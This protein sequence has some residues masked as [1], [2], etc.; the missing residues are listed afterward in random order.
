MK[1]ARKFITLW[2]LVFLTSAYAFDTTKARASGPSDNP[3]THFIIHF[4][5]D[6]SDT[7][8]EKTL[9]SYQL[10]L[11]KRALKRSHRAVEDQLLKLGA[12]AVQ[13]DGA[14]LDELKSLAKDLPEILSI[15]PDFVAQKLATTND[16]DLSKQWGLFTIQAASSN[17]TSTWDS[18]IGKPEV[19][20]AVLDTGVNSGHPDLAGVVTL[21]KDFANTSTGVIDADGHGT[22]VAGTISALGNNSIGGVGVAYGAKILNGKVL[23]DQGSGYYSSIASGITWAADNGAKVIN[24]S[25]GGT[26]DSIVLDNAIDYAVG[27]GSVVV[28]AAGNESTTKKLFPAAYAPVVSVTATDQNDVKPS[29]ANYG[30]WVDVAA[31]GVSIYSTVLGSN[32]AYYSGSSMATAVTSGAVAL[33]WSSGLCSSQTCVSD[34]LFTTADPISGTGS[35]FKYGRINTFKATSAAITVTPSLAPSP[36]PSVTESPTPSETPVATAS[37]TLIPSPTATPSPSPTELPSPTAALT[38]TPSEPT[39]TPTQTTHTMTSDAISMSYS[40][41]YFWYTISPI[42]HVQD[43]NKDNLSGAKVQVMFQ[44]PVGASYSRNTTTN[45]AGNA[46]FSFPYMFAKGTY[47]ITITAITKTGYSYAPSKTEQTIKIE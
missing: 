24:M 38:P 4:K 41:Q 5:K 23:D 40:K 6:A 1:F 3:S 39:P 46:S 2:I 8:R 10:K 44:S 21:S 20:V 13:I 42:I 26:A 43:E 15:E 45:T 25:L 37:P 31:P 34:K 9:I 17:T 35:T 19:L 29:W 18:T 27:K 28:A 32:Y 12:Q 16:P 11:K 22:H 30:T 7:K 33:I 36:S 14:K 47:K